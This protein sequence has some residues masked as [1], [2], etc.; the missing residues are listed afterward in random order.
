[1]RLAIQIEAT[2]IEIGSVRRNYEKGRVNQSHYKWYVTI[3]GDDN[4]WTMPHV[5][6]GAGMVTARRLE[7]MTIFRRKPV[8]IKIRN[9]F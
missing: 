7:K 2:L 9:V 1:M 3:Y 8:S 5:G 6:I 4:A